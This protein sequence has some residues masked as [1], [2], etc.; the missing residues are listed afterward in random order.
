VCAGADKRNSTQCHLR[1]RSAEDATQSGSR[2]CRPSIWIKPPNTDAVAV[3]LGCYPVVHSPV[4]THGT[5]SY[6][7]SSSRLRPR[8]FLLEGGK[9]LRLWH[10]PEIPHRGRSSWR[11]HDQHPPKIS[12]TPSCWR[13]PCQ[14]ARYK[15]RGLRS[16]DSPPPPFFFFFLKLIYDILMKIRRKVCWPSSGPREAAK[17][18]ALFQQYTGVLNDHHMVVCITDCLPPDGGRHRWSP[19]TLDLLRVQLETHPRKRM[20]RRTRVQKVADALP[21]FGI[22]VGVLGT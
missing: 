6:A 18:S 13:G 8:A 3:Q 12:R 2:N 5:R 17:E 22:V 15:A 9:V 20:I 14:R 19:R 7:P 16:A 21:V 4:G 11:L 10:P 1:F